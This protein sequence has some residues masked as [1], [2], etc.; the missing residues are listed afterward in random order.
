MNL[1]FSFYVDWLRDRTGKLGLLL[2]GLSAAV[3]IGRQSCFQGEGRDIRLHRANMDDRYDRS[4]CH[5]GPFFG[6]P[7]RLE[8]V[9]ATGFTL[10][11]KC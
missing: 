6:R 4:D 2:R 7:R 5:S 9:A 8:R 11:C 1:L 3:G 10:Y